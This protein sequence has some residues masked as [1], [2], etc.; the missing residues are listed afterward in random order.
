V[1]S[2]EITYFPGSSLDGG[3]FEW[4][5]GTAGSTTMLAFTLI[6]LG[7]FARRP[8]RFSMTGGLFQDFA[9]SFFHMKYVLLPLLRRM[10]AEVNLDMV[11]PGYVPRGQGQLVL[12]VKPLMSPLQPLSMVKPEGVKEM[13]GISFASHLERERVAERMAD[14]SRRLLEAEGWRGARIEI[15]NDGQAAQRGAALFLRAETV[16][17]SLLGADQAGKPGRRSEAIARFV[18]N[19]LVE[20]LRSQATTDRH[21]AD[22]LILFGAL[23]DGRTEYVIPAL[24]E[25][26]ESNLWLV[27]KMLGVE[28][29]LQ[30]NV[31]SLRGIGFRRSG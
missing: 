6:P 22:Q 29:E 12:E 8:C 26:V 30:G 11:R 7:L 20:D 5:I 31:L 23:A 4:N 1:G 3:D 28:S 24:S 21:L 15:R 27:R 16:N 10:G 14:E 17:G 9:P 25:H 13:R 19:C 18:V 2:T